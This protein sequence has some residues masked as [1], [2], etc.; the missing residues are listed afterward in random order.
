MLLVC[1]FSE[2]AVC[3]APLGKTS[4]PTHSIPQLLQ[5]FARVEA[6][7]SLPPTLS[8]LE[9]D[10]LMHSH[11][12]ETLWVQLLM[13]LGDGLSQQTPQSST[14]YNLSLPSSAMLLEP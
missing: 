12:S 9:L 1:M 5:F 13:L 14:S 2:I 4:C 7:W 8:I 10:P 6:L 11:A 3:C